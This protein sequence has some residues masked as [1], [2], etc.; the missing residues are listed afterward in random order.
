MKRKIETSL[1][2]LKKH[3]EMI[4]NDCKIDSIIQDLEDSL[5]TSKGYGLSA[6]QIGIP[7]Q[8]A[9]IRMGDFKLNLINPTII[10]KNNRIKSQSEGCLSLPGIRIDTVRYNDILLENKGEVLP[11]SGLEAI[12]I[13]HEIDHG[14]GKTILDRKWTKR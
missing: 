1:R 11:Y 4:A 6:I 7:F 2:K 8:I 10:S 5:D 12:V 3:S 13:Q 9:I 14:L